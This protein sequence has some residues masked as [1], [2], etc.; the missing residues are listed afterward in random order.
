M[1]LGEICDRPARRVGRLP[2]GDRLLAGPAG[3]PD[4]EAAMPKLS[5]L[6]H[7]GLYVRDLARMRDFY[8]RVLGLEV[9][10]ESAERR[11]VF[12][13]SRPAEEHHEVLLIERRDD[14]RRRAA[15]IPFAAGR[16]QR[17]EPGGTAPLQADVRGRGR[18]DHPDGHSREHGEH[19]LQGPRGQRPRGVLHRRAVVAAAF[20][21]LPSTSTGTT[22][23]SSAKS[24]RPSGRDSSRPDHPN[25]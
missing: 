2:G 17:G 24:R 10:D 20:L 22:R 7:V 1:T 25:P 3:P 18:R 23:R 14:V 19:L 9:T 6:G 16:L 12:L 8:T 13:S 21:L 15:S 5:S 4:E 11:M